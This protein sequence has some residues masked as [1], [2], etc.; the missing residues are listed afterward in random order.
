MNYSGTGGS[1]QQNIC[2]PNPYKCWENWNYCL[3]HG[4]DVDDN[5]TSGTCGKP[6]SMHNSNASCTNIM[7]RL[8]AGMHKTILPLTSCRTP[9]N[10]CPQQ[11]QRPQQR[12]P[13]AYYPPGGTAWQPPTTP[14]QYG[15]MPPANGT[16][17]QQMTIAM[18]VYQPG[19]G[20]MMD[21]RQY[22]Q[23][24]RN[25][26]M[27]QMGQQPMV[28]PMLMNNYAPNQQSNHMPDFFD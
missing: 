24:A 18:P 25:M 4:G 14:T 10:P 6:G 21:V 19:Q 26:P 17:R 2:P 12:P 11:Q 28:A 8:V 22:P 3:S 20:M 13:N 23:G 16:Y 9:P 5:H 27:M 1:Q 15:R 7:G